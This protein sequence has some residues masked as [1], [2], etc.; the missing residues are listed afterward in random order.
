MGGGGSSSSS[1]AR[2]CAEYCLL[3]ASAHKAFSHSTKHASPSVVLICISVAL[4][5]IVVGIWES[6]MRSQSEFHFLMSA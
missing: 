2:F 3:V 4:F 5:P 1:I 6:C